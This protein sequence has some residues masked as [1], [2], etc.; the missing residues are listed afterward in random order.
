MEKFKTWLMIF[1]SLNIIFWTMY[2]IVE[3]ALS[4]SFWIRPTGMLA[5]GAL[6]LLISNEH[7]NN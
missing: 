6:F 3:L 1:L 7:D 2:W 5:I 4:Y